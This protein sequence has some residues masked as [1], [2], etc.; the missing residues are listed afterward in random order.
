MS[1]VKKTQQREDDTFDEP[2]LARRLKVS[3]KTVYRR[4]VKGEI[5]F[6]RI[7]NLIRYD[8]RCYERILEKSRRNAA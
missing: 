3:P 8:D 7:G 6:Y 5:P 1:R 2:E 4:R